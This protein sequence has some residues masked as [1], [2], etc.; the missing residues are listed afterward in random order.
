M[1][2]RRWAIRDF[3]IGLP[4]TVAAAKKLLADGSNISLI[5]SAF[6]MPARRGIHA[7]RQKI[8]GQGHTPRR[9]QLIAAFTIIYHFCTLPMLNTTEAR[10]MPLAFP[11]PPC[12]YFCPRR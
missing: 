12:K 4:M 6:D 2:E 1:D 8:I 3:T 7:R 5:L 9:P 11:R 10:R